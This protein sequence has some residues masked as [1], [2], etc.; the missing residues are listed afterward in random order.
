MTKKLNRNMNKIIFMC[1]CIFM[2]F[3]N[4]NAHAQTSQCYRASGGHLYNWVT[5]PIKGEVY[6]RQILATASTTFLFSYPANLP[7]AYVEMRGGADALYP[8]EVV[9]MREMPGVGVRIRWMGH[10]AQG[11]YNFVPSHAAPSG[12]TVTNPYEFTLLVGSAPAS[13][14]ISYTFQY[15]VVVIDAKAYQGGK[16]DFKRSGIGNGRVFGGPLQGNRSLC[17]DGS[18]DLLGMLS[19]DTTVPELPRPSVST[20]ASAD[21]NVVA[22]MSPVMA[23]ELASAGSHRSEGIIG[24]YNFD[25][26]GKQCPVGTT[27]KAFFTDA[28]APSAS[29]A[30]VTSSHPEVGVRLY[31]R[32]SQTAI[33]LGPAPVGSTLPERQAVV[34]G[35]SAST[36]SDMYMPITAQYVMMPGVT[37]T[38]VTPG[39][40]NAEAVV[41]FMYD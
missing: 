37:K 7:K 28:R 41:T 23:S 26:V 24:Q 36:T 22:T 13:F 10:Y 1:F 30:Y 27:I 34:E 4:P 12:T 39:S 35:P 2:F 3:I 15:E 6:N 33:K 8:D 25:L 14:G 38:A 29:N 18:F 40:M 19:Q 11:S 9:P 16:P 17:R 21:L 31:H 32:D 5:Y 20:C